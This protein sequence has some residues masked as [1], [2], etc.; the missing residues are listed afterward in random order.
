V[1][2]RRRQLNQTIFNIVGL[3]V[4]VS[5]VMGGLLMTVIPPARPTPTPLP[6]R[7]RPTTLPATHTPLTT[8]EPTDAPTATSA[9]IETPPTSATV[10]PT[11]AIPPTVM[12]VPS[13]TVTL[14][15]TLPPTATSPATA[16]PVA[17]LL[18]TPIPPGS[19][20]VE[21]LIFADHIHACAK[22]TRDGVHGII[23][24]GVGAPLYARDH[25]QA[26]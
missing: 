12:P 22:E 3:V 7:P 8:T 9:T 17:G 13:A 15:M 1:K 6:T 18:A 23:T 24:G 2:R 10:T 16:T 25:L 21:R 5:M 4:V 26:F 11:L 20:D 14:T 19:K